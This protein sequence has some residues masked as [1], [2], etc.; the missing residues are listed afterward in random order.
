MK[1][2]EMI[3]RARLNTIGQALHRVAV[4][5][6]DKP[7]L[8]YL[9]REFSY[10]D[11]DDAATITARLL[12][13][14][15]VKPGDRVASYAKNSDAF[16]LAF[17]GSLRAAA[18]HVPINFALTGEE[19]VHALIDSG[20][21]YVFCDPDQYDKV[22][23]VRG[24]TAVQQVTLLH[25]DMDSLLAR[26]QL[27]LEDPEQRQAYTSG[28][29]PDSQAQS[30]DVVQLLYTSG[31]TSRPKGAIHTHESLMTHYGAVQQALD[32]TPQDRPVV[33]MPLYHSAGLHVFLTPYLLMGVTVRLLTVP[34]I[35]EILAKV[36]EDRATSLFLAPTVWVPLSQHPELEHR[37]LS[38]L[39][40]AYYGASIMPVTVLQRLRE[41]Y[42]KIGFYNCFGQSEMGP[43][44][45]VL[46]PED[47]DERP[48]SAGL[49]LPTVQIRVVDPEGQP[50]PEGTPGE[51]Q[52]RSP[53]L[54]RGYWN[55]D[56]ATAE[57]FADGWFH[58]GDQVVLD[59]DGYIEVVDR[60]KDV[61]N[62]GGILVASREVEDAIYRHDAVAE[63]A[64][65][66]RPDEKWIE[67]IT[68]YV[69]LKPDQ[70]LDADEL[71]EFLRPILAGFKIPKSYEFVDEL[72][73]NQSGKILKRQLR[74]GLRP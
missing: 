50:V 20:S 52:Y 14:A 18:V 73:R 19:L 23:E 5:S 4:G 16:V 74:G 37:D 69:V 11:L 57:S 32:F 25:G 40:H 9:Q 70:Q 35:S 38:S 60:I 58:S 30:S 43:L 67:S 39:T 64:V 31:T 12:I 72:P 24:D 56:E 68:A 13:E 10:R 27:I 28:E 62:T 54:C 2:S 66:G 36:E 33:C 22:E 17:F 41:A 42:P 6:P 1:T 21:T 15:G 65:I 51:I 3:Q 7:A 26:V 63:V 61:I 44:V 53:Q 46:R 59:E 49:P 55:R 8:K 48:K 29:T 47:H 34:D 71:K 45:S